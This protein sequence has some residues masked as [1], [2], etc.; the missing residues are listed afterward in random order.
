MKPVR[1]DFKS[2]ALINQQAKADATLCWTCGTCDAECPIN[3]A[4]NRLSPRKIVRMATIGLIDEMARLPEIWYCMACNRCSRTCPTLVT[5]LRMISRIREEA[6]RQGAVSV[7][8]LAEYR[9]FFSAFQRVR[10]HV[11]AHCFTDE[12][13]YLSDS[14]WY[15]WLNAP[16]AA[17]H[18]AISGEDIMKRR[19]GLGDTLSAADSLACFT[20]S[21]CTNACPLKSERS[22]FDP[23]SITRMANLGLTDELLRSPAIW[24]CVQCG[25]CSESCSQAVKVHIL[26]QG[27]RELAMKKGVVDSGFQR[28]LKKADRIVYP[29]FV[30]EVD[31]ILGANRRPEEAPSAT[32]THGMAS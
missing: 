17:Q 26:I 11:V 9:K 4:T 3:D 18:T 22:V 15:D 31:R 12:L 24:L 29:R 32:G 10:W 21:E 13:T 1:P 6:L 23:V 25:Q 27:L 30:E 8:M 5:P 2:A 28:R 7:D 19:N 20:C 16:I 14:Q